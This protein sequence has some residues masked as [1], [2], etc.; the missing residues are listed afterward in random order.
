MG[1][2]NRIIDHEKKEISVEE[3]VDKYYTNAEDY[4][5]GSFSNTEG[6]QLFD[7]P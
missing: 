3:T 4:F 2:L 1:L 6:A 7:L 5:E